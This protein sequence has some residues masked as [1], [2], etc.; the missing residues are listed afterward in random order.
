MNVED[1]RVALDPAI[2][3]YAE[4]CTDIQGEPFKA[5]LGLLAAI[6][7]YARASE[8][9]GH[10]LAC[11]KD[12]WPDLPANTDVTVSEAERVMRGCGNAAFGKVWYCSDA[13]IKE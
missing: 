11:I 1:A 13:P 4:A 12:N 9:R 5:K 2:D 6:G 8:L 7:A 3:A 10:V